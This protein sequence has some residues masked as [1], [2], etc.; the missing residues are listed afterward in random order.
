MKTNNNL[1]YYFI[2]ITL[3]VLLKIGY[4][5]ANNDLLS[6]LLLPTSSIIELLTGSNYSYLPEH[7]YYFIKLNIT[8]D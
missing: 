3:F 1:I 7:G 4:T 5:Q 6:F 8:I 2:T